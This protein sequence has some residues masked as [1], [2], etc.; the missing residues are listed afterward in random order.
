MLEQLARTHG[1][2]T[3][4][5][6]AARRRREIAPD[7]LLAVLRALGVPIRRPDDAP[8]LLR[9]ALRERVN[10]VLEPVTVAWRNRPANVAMQLPECAAVGPLH[11]EW[12]WEDGSVHRAE[13]RLERLRVRRVTDADGDRFVTLELPVPKRRPAGYHRVFVEWAS[14]RS[15]GAVFAAPEQCYEDPVRQRTWGVFA[16]AYALHSARS[17]G[18][19]DLSDLHGFVTW[20]GEHGGRFVGTLPLLPAFLDQPFELSPYS[21]VSR[22]F[23]N[24]FYL[25][26]TQ[27]PEVA[28]CTAARRRIESSVFQSRVDRLRRNPLVDYREEMALKREVL[29]LLS[30]HFF[31]RPSVRRAAFER[32]IRDHPAIED[33]ARFRAVAE[34]RP[35]PWRRWPGRLREGN[36]YESDYRLVDWQYQLYVQWLAHEQMSA[37]SEHARAIGVDLYLDLPLGT[38]RDGYDCWRFRDL[39]A[40]NASGGAPPDS[41]FT[42]GQD[43]GFAPIHPERSRDQGH[44]Y[45][46]ACLRHHFRHAAMLRLDHAMSLHR[47]YWV[48]MGMPADCG[49]YV[50]YPAEEFYAVLSLESHR[51][52]A[53]VV[54][55]NLGTVPPEVNRGLAR[56]RVAEMFVGQYEFQSPPRLALRPAPARSVAG[57]NTHD[58]PPFHS[59]WRGL[60]L[61]DRRALGLIR[62]GDLPRE[63]RRRTRLRQNLTK[64]LRWC[65]WLGENAMDA[66]SMLR[67]VLAHL[68]AS[69]ARWVLLNLEDLWLE[70][71]PQNVPGTST[72]RINWR[73]K[74]RFAREQFERN[75]AIRVQLRD[76]RLRRQRPA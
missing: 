29:G 57:L 35:Q 2:Q 66:G 69:K 59:Y 8:A 50:T 3:H 6:D 26:I 16:P 44:A 33:Y 73:R 15:E 70:T 11:V 12:R 34:R 27:I 28:E 18:A 65:G 10:R 24:E 40:L 68:A 53:V 22:L 46:T 76:I 62:A 4:Y 9:A 19:G 56:H 48:P 25:D 5:H 49:A 72:E 74:A 64:L 60:D 17:W 39:F 36:L 43:W 58:M 1:V 31:A 20:V 23:W 67:A 37:L 30:R 75:P 42:H 51:H 55:E 41:V 45:W 38:H 32:F 47:L 21:P 61:A 14:Q 7:S 71:R 52:C 13:T 54:G 63:Q